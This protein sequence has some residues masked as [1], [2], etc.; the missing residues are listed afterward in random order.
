MISRTMEKAHFMPYPAC[1]DKFNGISGKKLI[2]HIRLKKSIEIKFPK[3]LYIV[4]FFI[5]GYSYEEKDNTECS[6][7]YGLLFKELRNKLNESEVA[8]LY[9]VVTI[10]Q[11]FFK[12][13]IYI[14]A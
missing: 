8:K 11:Y 10:I 12:F 4:F 3:M 13:W 5:L 14:I 6:I 9:I 1:L 7:S 2:T